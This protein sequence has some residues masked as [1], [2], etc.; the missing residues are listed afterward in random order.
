MRRRKWRLHNI[1]STI[2]FGLNNPFSPLLFFWVLLHYKNWLLNM[3]DDMPK[4]GSF[5]MC[6]I[7]FAPL[8]Q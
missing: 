8:A 6:N 1:E 2:T 3:L 7:G 5:V 4:F